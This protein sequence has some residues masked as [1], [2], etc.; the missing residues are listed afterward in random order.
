MGKQI[1]I[2]ALL[3]IIAHTTN[4]QFKIGQDIVGTP[5]DSR[6]TEGYIGDAY[7]YP[8]WAIGHVLQEDEKY[9]N[10]ML[11]KYDIYNDRIIFKSHGD[12]PMAFKYAVKEFQ[13][14]HKNSI[15]EPMA[16]FK[17]GFPE[18]GKYNSKSYYQILTEGKTTLVKKPYKSIVESLPY[19]ESEKKKTFVANEIY[20]LHH[21]GKMIKLK[22]SKKSL[23]DILSDK[24]AE[25]IAFMKDKNLNMKSEEDYVSVVNYYNSL[26]LL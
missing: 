17:N 8:D 10:D 15:N 21:Q 14:I 25:L 13:I 3:T 19:G 20:F 9:F 5:Y 26:H 2:G 7:L 18:I 24:K 16:L 4:A 11:L 23:I 22:K 6:R 12:I 1:I